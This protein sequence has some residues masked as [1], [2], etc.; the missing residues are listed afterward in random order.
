MPLQDAKG[1]KTW[2][3]LPSYL[4]TLVCRAVVI[5]VEVSEVCI[6][7]FFVHH[8]A[9]QIEVTPQRRNNDATTDE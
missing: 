1:G 4:R 8:S 3:C 9:R 7:C 2:P 5:I 6:H